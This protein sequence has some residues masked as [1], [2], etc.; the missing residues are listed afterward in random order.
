M[1]GT[2]I[3]EIRQGQQRSLADVASEVEISVATLSRIE[4]DKQT[5]DLGLF[6]VLAKALKTSPHDFFGDDHGD[7]NGGDKDLAREI[8]ALPLSDRTQLWQNL[9]SEQRILRARSKR[10]SDQQLG[11]HVEELLAQLDF[12][13]EEL[14][15]VKRRLRKR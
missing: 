8:A 5:L 1:V 6:L 15:S 10:E 2:K 4:N 9:A 11:A 14:E 13:R 12:V 3:R 7:G